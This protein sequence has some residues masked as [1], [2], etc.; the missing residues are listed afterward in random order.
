MRLGPLEGYVVAVTADRRAAEQAELLRRRGARVLHAPAIATDYLV[1][2]D[3]VGAATR[4]AVEVRPEFVV[5]LTGIGVRAWVEA[6]QS[7]GLDAAL[8]DALAGARVLT[9]GAKARAAAHAAGLSVWRSAASEQVTE[10]IEVLRAEARPGQ[11]V[12]VQCHGG[13][14]ARIR[15]VLA[16]LGVDVL[17]VPV[18]RWRLP[19][20]PAPARRLV[21]AV[22]KR[23]VDA[24]TF[25]SAP[26]VR[27]LVELARREGMAEQVVEGFNAGVLAACIGPVCAAAARDVGI[28]APV[29]PDV[30]RLGVLARLVSNELERRAHAFR[31]GG[32]DVRV[33]G[34]ALEVGGE[35]AELSHRER[36]VLEALLDRR[37]AVVAPRALPGPGGDGHARAVEAAV[38][39]LRRKL[40]PAGVAIEAVRRRGYRLAADQSQSSGGPTSTAAHL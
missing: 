30:G 33:Q 8:L 9:R 26:A 13:D 2:D 20:D 4:A 15:D 32:V 28:E 31:A 29:A 18:Y 14:D 36:A 17:E 11:R 22:A 39:R 37:G 21:H 12:V 38:G 25:T 27:N 3:A 35:K 19:C 10:L 16:P 23:R 40:G 24:V 7:W 34:S 1:T 6:A 5:L